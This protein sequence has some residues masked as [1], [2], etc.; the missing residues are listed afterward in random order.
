MT[1]RIDD[2]TWI[3]ASRRIVVCSFPL[4]TCFFLFG[5]FILDFFGVSV[6]VVRFSGGLV[7]ASIGWGLLNQS[8][9][10]SSS[11]GHQVEETA[12]SLSS[13]LFYPYTF[14]ATIGPGSMAVAPTFGA[15]LR[16]DSHLLETMEKISAIIGILLIAVV[17]SFCHARLK[18]ITKKFSP[19]G[20]QALSRILAFF[21]FCIGVEIAWEGWRA[22]NTQGCAPDVLHRD[23]LPTAG[24]TWVPRGARSHSRAHPDRRGCVQLEATVKTEPAVAGPVSHP[25]LSADPGTGVRLK[26]P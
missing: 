6:P 25:A 22:L 1:G 24:T 14:P 13:K 15:P 11:S 21:V 5:D 9:A 20:A 18:W 3:S 17:T 12:E 4:L 10:A 16:R 8:S 23:N 2:K 26:G 19:A 7:V